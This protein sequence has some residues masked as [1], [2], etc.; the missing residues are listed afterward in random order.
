[1]DWVGWDPKDHQVAIP[2]PQAGLPTARIF[3]LMPTCLSLCSTFYPIPAKHF[4]MATLPEHS[5]LNNLSYFLL[6]SV[7]SH[8]CHV[9]R[10]A[11][12]KLDS[13]CWSFGCPWN[14]KSPG[15]LIWHLSGTLKSH[16]KSERGKIITLV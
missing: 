15:L 16:K 9:A 4:P 11:W 1:M 12:Q 10:A 2:L 6:W 13:H 8:Q 3:E 14:R 5:D 7:Q